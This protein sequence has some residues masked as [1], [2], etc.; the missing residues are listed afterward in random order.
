MTGK[1]DSRMTTVQQD[2]KITS[3][4]ENRRNE[5]ERTFQKKHEPER[6]SVCFST[7]GSDRV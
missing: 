7:W 2:W 6:L 3:K 4:D 1:E 5:A